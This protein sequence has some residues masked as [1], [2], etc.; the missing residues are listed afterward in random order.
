MHDGVLDGLTN[1]HEQ[2]PLPFHTQ[3]VGRA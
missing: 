2:V 1:E 3:G